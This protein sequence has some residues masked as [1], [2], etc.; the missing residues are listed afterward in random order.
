[1]Y[2]GYLHDE[3]AYRESFAGPWY[4]TGDAAKRDADGYYWF[5]ARNDDIIKTSGHR[6]GPFEIESVLMEHPAVSEVGVIGKPDPL[7]GEAI[8]AF[9][10]VSCPVPPSGFGQLNDN[11]C[12]GCHRSSQASHW[13]RSLPIAQDAPAVYGRPATCKTQPAMPG[14]RATFF[15]E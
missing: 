7:I 1:M 12:I 9:A 10:I 2:R 5:V 13:K 3:Q 15:P 8:Q 4:L 14:G 11:D 6:V